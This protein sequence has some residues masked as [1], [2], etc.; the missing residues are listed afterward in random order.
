MKYALYMRRLDLAG[1]AA[2]EEEVRAAASQTA[3]QRQRQRQQDRLEWLCG[4]KKEAQRL[5][6]G[7]DVL[8]APE[9]VECEFGALRGSSTGRDLVGF[10]VDRDLSVKQAASWVRD[11]C[12]P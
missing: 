9:E 5:G 1:T 8:P 4:G 10:R 2:S 6:L 7:I 3:G 12:P 11:H